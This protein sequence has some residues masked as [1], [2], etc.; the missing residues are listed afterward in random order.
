MM[1]W[2][3]FRGYIAMKHRESMKYDNISIKMLKDMFSATENYR[4]F[5]E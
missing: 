1:N 2:K 3:I 4:L 5:W